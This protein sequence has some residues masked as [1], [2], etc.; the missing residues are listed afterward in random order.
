MFDVLGII[1]KIKII[2]VIFL[3]NGYL[4]FSQNN[5]DELYMEAGEL[6]ADTIFI[7]DDEYSV[8][9][10]FGFYNNPF[11]NEIDFC[12]YIFIN[13]NYNCSVYSITD[14]EVVEIGYDNEMNN[15]IKIKYNDFIIEYGN[16]INIIVNIGDSIIMG[17]I[18]GNGG[19]L[20]EPYGN[21]IKIRIQYKSVTINPNNILN[22]DENLNTNRIYTN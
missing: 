13:S 19:L 9:N 20:S 4:S 21:G 3:I 2:L 18:I 11:N 14:G 15:Y 12:D 6:L 22:Y 16:L 5:M 1:M 17:Q 10:I 7:M 8:F